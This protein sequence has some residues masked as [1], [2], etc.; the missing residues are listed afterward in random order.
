[1]S[2]CIHFMSVIY[3][4]KGNV[5]RLQIAFFFVPLKHLWMFFHPSSPQTTESHVDDWNDKYQTFYSI[6]VTLF[7]AT[8]TSNVAISPAVDMHFLLL[9][10]LWTLKLWA[11]KL[12]HHSHSTHP[13]SLAVISQ[14]H[15]HYTLTPC[16]SRAIQAPVN[17][18]TVP[19]N[20]RWSQMEI[21]ELQL[22]DGARWRNRDETYLSSKK[23]LKKYPPTCPPASAC[24]A[25]S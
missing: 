8:V 7:W 11:P 24:Y 13:P 4:P 1:M 20:C 22:E 5:S 23:E 25:M 15:L 21:I 10:L 17:L 2:S 16:L 3:F 12:S 14:I 9:T 6:V 18:L 19:D